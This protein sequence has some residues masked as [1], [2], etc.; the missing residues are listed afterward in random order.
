[1]QWPWVTTAQIQCQM[2][3]IWRILMTPPWSRQS[4]SVRPSAS[5]CP[6][7]STAWWLLWLA[8]PPPWCTRWSTPGALKP[9]DW[10]PLQRA[11]L[12]AGAYTCV[13][14]KKCPKWCGGLVSTTDSISF[15]V[16]THT[17]A[18]YVSLKLSQ[19]TATD[20]SNI[21]CGNYVRPHRLMMINSTYG[22]VIPLSSVTWNWIFFS[23]SIQT[24]GADSLFF[25]AVLK[26]VVVWVPCVNTFHPTRFNKRERY[27]HPHLSTYK[28]IP[29]RSA[30][31][32]LSN[33]HM[34]VCLWKNDVPPTYPTA[35][36]IGFLV[37]ARDCF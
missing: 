1:M 4:W 30:E 37:S 16:E 8:C 15:I 20:Y 12:T 6:Q 24:R 31:G 11:L 13:S 29:I 5:W 27:V 7:L 28:G 18:Q 19:F 32:L 17:R 34:H 21:C 2:T 9:L 3:S 26:V 35:I 10:R 33:T 36:T 22:N 23:F 25:Q 14:Y